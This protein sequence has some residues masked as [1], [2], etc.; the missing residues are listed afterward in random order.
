MASET[1]GVE[2]DANGHGG[3]RN[4]YAHPMAHLASNP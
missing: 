2:K 4:G 3:T 1:T